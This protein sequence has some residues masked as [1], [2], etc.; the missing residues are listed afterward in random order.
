VHLLSGD[1]DSTTRAVAAQA[2][3]AD[4]DARGGMSPADKLA[5]IRELQVRFR[6]MGF[7]DRQIRVW[8]WGGDGV[9]FWGWGVG[10]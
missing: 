10:G 7:L 2:G 3:I 1:D 8:G 6:Q 5:R 4:A 9:P